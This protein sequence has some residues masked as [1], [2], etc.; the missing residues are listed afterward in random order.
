M[1][2]VQHRAATEADLR[3][4]VSSWLS[5]YRTSSYAGMISMEDWDLVMVPQIR[6]ALGRPGVD[7][8]VAYHPQGDPDSDIIGWIAVEWGTEVPTRAQEKGRW[9]ETMAPSGCGYVLFTFVK[10][11]YRKMGVARGLFEKA[12]VNPLERFLYAC[13]TPVVSQFMNK[14]R[15]EWAPLVVR[16]PKKRPEFKP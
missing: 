13:R 9:V 1:A 14:A 10:Q 16:Y 5:S 8:W 11:A 15:A 4:V 2:S 7:V 12:G 3:F 6:K